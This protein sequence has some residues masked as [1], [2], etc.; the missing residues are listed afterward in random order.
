[1]NNGLPYHLLLSKDTLSALNAE[2]NIARNVWIAFS[3]AIFVIVI[4]TLNITHADFLIGKGN[5]SKNEWGLA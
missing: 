4:T 3:L 2:A 1:M 5:P